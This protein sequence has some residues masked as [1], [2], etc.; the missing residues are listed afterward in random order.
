MDIIA[1]NKIKG[2]HSTMNPKKVSKYN[3]T[4]K[5]KIEILGTIAKKAVILVGDP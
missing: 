1:H 4:N 3:L 2:C 5:P